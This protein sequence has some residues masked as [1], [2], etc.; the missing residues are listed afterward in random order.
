[1]AYDLENNEGV[2]AKMGK[3]GHGGI[4]LGSGKIRS[5]YLLGAKLKYSLAFFSPKIQSRRCFMTSINAS[6]YY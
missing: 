4:Y 6:C 2:M 1:M 5:T 3:Y